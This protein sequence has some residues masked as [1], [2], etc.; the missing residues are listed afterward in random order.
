MMH[1]IEVERDGRWWMV[2]IPDLGGLTQAR[3]IS[4]VELMAREWIAVSTGT[5]INDVS[6]HIASITVDGR[7][8]LGEAQHVNDL[9][10]NASRAEQEA[11]AVARDYAR[12]LTHAGVP[13]RDV[14]ALLDI[15]PQ[16]VSQLTNKPTDQQ[17][18][19]TY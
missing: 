19:L 14:A 6:V 3:R 7:D 2:R 11:V 8:V 18:T 10:R 15:S 13:V 16:R 9:R 1:K 12:Q 4:E 17:V 5:P